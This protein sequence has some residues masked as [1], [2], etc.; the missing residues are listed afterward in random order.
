MGVSNCSKRYG[1]IFNENE[2]DVLA[3][4]QLT[5]VSAIDF[6]LVP[7]GTTFQITNQELGLNPAM[8]ITGTI[9]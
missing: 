1:T 5:S 7:R 4:L 6:D 8:K 9:S 2:H 3:T